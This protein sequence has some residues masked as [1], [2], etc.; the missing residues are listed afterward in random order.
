MH[1][2]KLLFFCVQESLDMLISETFD[3]RNVR[4]KM[5]ILDVINIRRI[6]YDEEYRTLF[7]A[8]SCLSKN[9]FQHIHLYSLPIDEDPHLEDKLAY[10]SKH[11][12]DFV[13]SQL[14]QRLRDDSRLDLN[15]FSTSSLER[16]TNQF[17]VNSLVLNVENYLQN[18]DEITNFDI[19]K[20]PLN[21]NVRE[22]AWQ[23]LESKKYQ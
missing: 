23:A 20:Q 11:K 3:S 15:A 10:L 9:E 21:L 4:T 16:Q 1:L 18:Y 19:G 5:K 17:V 14:L 22:C 2:I 6:D 12:E 8:P 13:L 7:T